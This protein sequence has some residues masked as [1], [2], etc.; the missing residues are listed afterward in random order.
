MSEEE[1]VR[2][3]RGIFKGPPSREGSVGRLPKP[4]PPLPTPA[5]KEPPR[6]K[7]SL[8][9]EPKPD[10]SGVLIG[11]KGH[12][13]QP[14]SPDCSSDQASPTATSGDRSFQSFLSRLGCTTTT[15]GSTPRSPVQRQQLLGSPIKKNDNKFPESTEQDKDPALDKKRVRK[16]TKQTTAPQKSPQSISPP[17]RNSS[18]TRIKRET[19]SPKK[20]TSLSRSPS[21]RVSPRGV[22]PRKVSPRGGSR[23]STPSP[24][25]FPSHYTPT[26]TSV[27]TSRTVTPIRAVRKSPRNTSKSSAYK[28]TYVSPSP[29]ETTP[30]WT[31]D[32]TPWRD[33]KLKQ[34][35]SKELTTQTQSNSSESIRK[36]PR[37][38]EQSN[39]QRRTA[40]PV[41]SG[42]SPRRSVSRPS[43]YMDCSKVKWQQHDGV[44]EDSLCN[45]RGRTSSMVSTKQS[46]PWRASLPERSK[47]PWRED[48]EE[49]NSTPKT[50]CPISGLSYHDNTMFQSRREHVMNALDRYNIPNHLLSFNT[51]SGSGNSDY[52]NEEAERC[53]RK[54][55]METLNWAT[56]TEGDKLKEEI[57]D[58]WRTSLDSEVIW[59]DQIITPVIPT[60]ASDAEVFSSHFVR[61]HPTVPEATTVRTHRSC[62]V[63][64]IRMAS[65]SPHQTYTYNPLQG[66]AHLSDRF[67]HS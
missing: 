49:I 43:G 21:P 44:W 58:T 14:G 28:Q 35:K 39:H 27:Q 33:R 20:R 13:P 66:L 17:T 63:G 8:E 55:L 6:R 4:P 50:V 48:L 60:I 24:S 37:R 42:Y 52:R 34:K 1:N 53:S 22:S 19:S 51:F 31:G 46:S 5:I 15:V 16:T 45:G 54:W 11:T 26:P 67:S 18:I 59:K 32:L 57:I 62:H 12:L 7:D 23:S 47:S 64:C 38:R 61:Y 25:P 40:T 9:T 41:S 10:L 65:L 2:G 29:L 3:F 56:E 30:R 36:T